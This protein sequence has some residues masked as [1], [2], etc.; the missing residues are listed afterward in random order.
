A[1]AW[2]R[3]SFGRQQRFHTRRQKRIDADVRELGLKSGSPGRQEICRIID[4]FSLSNERWE[5]R[6]NRI[7]RAR[8]A[9]SRRR[10][11]NECAAA[12]R[13]SHLLSCPLAIDL[14]RAGAQRT[15]KSNS[16]HGRAQRSEVRG[17]RSEP[18]V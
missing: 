17:Q 4:R 10:R 3:H 15:W 12:E 9:C 7:G 6:G 13:T 8:L 2:R 16:R 18:I 1:A 11:N 5:R 14:N